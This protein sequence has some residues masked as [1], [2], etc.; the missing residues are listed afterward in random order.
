MGSTT[1]SPAKTAV[2]RGTQTSVQRELN[3]PPS[4]R[5]S[6]RLLYSNLNQSPSQQSVSQEQVEVNS[7]FLKDASKKVR[8]RTWV[9]FRPGVESTLTGM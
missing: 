9:R 4:G 5:V 8:L 2:A 6:G 3:P 1:E 7:V